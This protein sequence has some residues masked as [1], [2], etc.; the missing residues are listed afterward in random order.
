MAA[1]EDVGDYGQV[2]VLGELVGEELD[3]G[4]FYAEYVSHDGDCIGGGGIAWA[5]EAAGIGVW[6]VGRVCAYWWLVLG[7]WCM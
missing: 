3:V 2:P 6:G 1:V 5:V 7:E 4:E